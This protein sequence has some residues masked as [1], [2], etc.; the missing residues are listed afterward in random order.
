[1][2]NTPA[3]K[4]PTEKMP[5]EKIPAANM[6]ALKTPVAKLPA[7]RYPP[8]KS[9]ALKIGNPIMSLTPSKMSMPATARSKT[10]TAPMAI[11]YFADKKI[12]ASI[13]F[14]R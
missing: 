10:I 5:A 7:A 4:I 13:Q 14:C 12:P 2:L 9:P 3:E 8:A 11:E 1:M 6:P